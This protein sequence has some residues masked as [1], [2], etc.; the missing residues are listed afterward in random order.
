MLTCAGEI[1]GEPFPPSKQ[2]CCE[3][4]TSAGESRLVLGEVQDALDAAP[5]AP[6]PK[7]HP[8]VSLR[9]PFRCRTR[10]LHHGGRHD[11]QFSW[12]SNVHACNDHIADPLCVE[13]VACARCITHVADGDSRQHFC[14]ELIRCDHC[15]VTDDLLAIDAHQLLRDIQLAIV[16]KHGIAHIHEVFVVLARHA[17]H[18][19]HCTQERRVPHVPGEHVAIVH[20]TVLFQSLCECT[21]RI[22][23]EHLPAEARICCVV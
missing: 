2:E 22:S 10:R 3:Q 12:S 16:P 19:K 1:A 15:G 9:F 17:Q 20:Q 21:E 14:L 8:I 6:L 4:V 5:L 18:I 13:P 7:Q 11:Q 23:V